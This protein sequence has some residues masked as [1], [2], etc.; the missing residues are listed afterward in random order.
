VAEQNPL[1]RC[2]AV[3]AECDAVE[4]WR[5]TRSQREHYATAL[6]A[7]IATDLPPHSVRQVVVNYH[8]DHR[9]VA[10]LR[11][12][13]HPD[14][15]IRWIRWTQRVQAVLA[16]AGL[17]WSSDAAVDGEDLTQIALMALA[18]A[19]PSYRYR[20]RF[21]VW[22]YSVVTRAI[23]R[24]IRDS[25]RERRAARPASLDQLIAAEGESGPATEDDGASA[26]HARLL[27]EHVRAVLAGH[28]D[29]RLKYLFH[30]AYVE[31]R[32]MAEI[33][34]AVRLHHS[35]V[36]TL[37]HQARTMLHN[38]PEIQAWRQAGDEPRPGSCLEISHA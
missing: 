4:G 36:R 23:R 25:L 31:G 33:G 30:L 38:D 2:L 20:S 28:P 1:H 11:D 12:A 13:Q 9:L 34:G 8:Q 15:V 7:I 14:H 5:L 17:N 16:Q 22:A 10:I 27:Y 19:L 18:R 21:N 3:V 6:A 26:A 29:R 35:R 32:S 37:L 24:H